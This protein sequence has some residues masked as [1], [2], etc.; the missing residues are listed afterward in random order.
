VEQELVLRTDGGYKIIYTSLCDQVIASSSQCQPRHSRNDKKKWGPLELGFAANHLD[1]RKPCD[2]PEPKAGELLPHRLAVH[3]APYSRGFSLLLDA[4]YALLILSR[5]TEQSFDLG[6]HRLP[7]VATLADRVRVVGREI[8]ALMV[9]DVL[10]YRCMLSQLPCGLIALRRHYE[11]LREED[12]N[13]DD[14]VAQEPLLQRNPANA[15]VQHP[16]QKK[17]NRAA[18]KGAGK[19]RQDQAGVAR[20]GVGQVKAG[21]E[22]E[23]AAD[24]HEQ[25][26][27]RVC[28]FVL[29]PPLQRS[30]HTHDR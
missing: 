27:Y 29:A 6:E 19:H 7:V 23:G 5:P 16:V 3:H 1:N 25:V 22:Y 14:Q 24:G 4:N 28:C 21:N 20:E 9:D 10:H 13:G 8:V 18:V 17:D 26:G 15:L 2:A 30:E 12:E 11:D